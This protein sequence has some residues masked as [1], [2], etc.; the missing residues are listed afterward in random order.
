MNSRDS[1]IISA[2]QQKIKWTRLWCSEDFLLPGLFFLFLSHVGY[3]Q[4]PK[5]SEDSEAD[6]LTEILARWMFP[7]SLKHWHPVT[8]WLCVLT[9]GTGSLQVRYDSENV[10]HQVWSLFVLQYA[11]RGG[12]GRVYIRQIEQV[13]PWNKA[14]VRKMKCVTTNRE[15]HATFCPHALSLKWV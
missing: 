15:K 7:A 10:V 11:A 6:F 12:V 2:C 8:A 5:N 9:I 3:N 13:H 14:A 1:F 4:I